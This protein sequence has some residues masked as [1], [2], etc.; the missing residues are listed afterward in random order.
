MSG[1]C[2]QELQ[3]KMGTKWQE[4]DEVTSTLVWAGSLSSEAQTDTVEFSPGQ[5]I[6]WFEVLLLL[7]DVRS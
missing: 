4:T 3:Q 5:N 7:L 6:L 1:L 2:L